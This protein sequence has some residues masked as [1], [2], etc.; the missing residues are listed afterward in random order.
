MGAKQK[1]AKGT[2]VKKTVTKPD[3]SAK[4][5]VALLGSWRKA[6][7]KCA[8]AALRELQAIIECRDMLHISGGVER[9]TLDEIEV[10]LCE[11]KRYSTSDPHGRRSWT[12]NTSHFVRLRSLFVH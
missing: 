6:R 5:Y 12:C 9:L 1:E 3:K 7:Q 10:A 8:I 4:A 2:T 11:W